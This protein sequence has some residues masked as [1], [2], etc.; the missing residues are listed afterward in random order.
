MPKHTI[1]SIIENCGGSKAIANNIEN[2]KYDS[3]RK[4]KIFGIPE[5]HWS[6][7]IRLHKKRLSPNRLHKLNK[8]C[9]GDFT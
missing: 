4:W 6:T 1:E 8:I 3:V 2:L 7:I 9:R 5:R